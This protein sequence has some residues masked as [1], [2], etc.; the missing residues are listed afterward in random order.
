MDNPA[1]PIEQEIESNAEDFSEAT[2]ADHEAISDGETQSDATESEDEALPVYYDID[3]EEVSLEDVRKWKSGH[4]MQSDYTKKTQEVAEERKTVQA[5]RKQLSEGLETLAAIESEIE[6]LIIGD[7]SNLDQ[8]LEEGDTEQY[9]RTQKQLEARKGKLAEVKQKYAK[10]KE[11]MLSE[12]ATKLHESLG[13]SD[14]E[15]GQAKKQA[16]IAA[17]NDYRQT[18]GITD[19]EFSSVTSPAIIG[20]ILEAAKYRKLM[21]EKPSVTKKVVKTPK[22]VKPKVTQETKVLSLAERMYGTN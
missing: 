2:E 11:S 3:G 10:L 9:L 21:A 12:A 18:A 14:P 15:K 16:D 4:M 22:A 19:A 13:W 5:E 1:E 8:L 17:I 7:Q 6:G 20:A